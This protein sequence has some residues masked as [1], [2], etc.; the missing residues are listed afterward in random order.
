MHILI[1]SLKILYLDVFKNSVNDYPIEYLIDENLL[2]YL[3]YKLDFYKF[4]QISN[5]EYV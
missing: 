3:S 5:T 1:I 2:I 4:D